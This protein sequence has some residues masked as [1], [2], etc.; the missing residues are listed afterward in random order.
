[1]CERNS[2]LTVV[3]G[4]LEVH[5]HN[6]TGPDLGHSIAIQGLHLGELAGRDL[7]A[8][9][10]GEED[11]DGIIGELFGTSL[12]FGFSVRGITTPR[13]NVVSPEVNSVIGV[14]AVEVVSHV[15]TNSGHIGGSI[16]N[17]H[18]AVAL[19]LD[20]LLGVTNSSLDESAG[21]GSGDGVGNLIS[22][23]ETN[24][25]VVLGKFIDNTGVSGKEIGLPRRI[26]SI[27]RLIG[28]GQIGDHVN[29]SGR[30][31]LHTRRVVS[32]SV[33]GIGTDDVGTQLRHDRNIT[34][35]G[36]G[37]GERVSVA[38]ATRTFLC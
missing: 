18:R 15:R 27:D 33:D 35:T 8:T 30:Q 2:L 29:T 32:R 10:L 20:V 34:R 36:G 28:V 19:L 11:R 9:V 23:E 21:V 7:V 24:S 25:V 3:V 26:A 17:T 37:I 6:T 13:V 1:M 5:V 22:S 38:T 12:V 31:E 4:L 16:S 14:S